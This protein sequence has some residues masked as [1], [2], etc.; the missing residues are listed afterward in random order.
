MTKFGQKVNRRDLSKPGWREDPDRPGVDRYWTGSEWD[1]A[2]PAR[3]T[4]ASSTKQLRLIV[5]GIL[6]AAAIVFTIWRLQQPSDMDCLMQ[7]IEVTTGERA[8]VES[9][10]VGR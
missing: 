1:D 2:I 5:L 3:S 4:P 9:A 6:V 7:Q 8:A 10:C